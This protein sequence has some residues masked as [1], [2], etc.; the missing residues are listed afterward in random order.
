M[1]R[2]VRLMTAKLLRLLFAVALLVLAGWTFNSSGQTLT[3]LWSF[4]NGVD[5]AG[6][7]AG[8]VQ[9]SDGNLYGTTGSP[10]YPNSTSTVY[11]ITPSGIL[12]NLHTFSGNDGINPNALVQDAGSFF[13]G[14]T[15]G[16]FSGPSISGTVFRISADGSFTNLYTFSGSDGS[17]PLA[18]L[19]QGTDGNFY[20]TTFSG[21]VSN[22]GTVFQISPSG[23]FTNLYSF[24]G[25]DGA[26]PDGVL[27]QGIDGNFYGIA[28][29][30]GTNTNVPVFGTPFPGPGTVFRI[31]PSGSFTNLHSFN[32]NDGTL[33]VGGLAR[34]SDGYFYGTTF[35]GGT[36]GNNGT[37][38]RITPSGSLTSLWSFTGFSDGASPNAGLVQGSDGL[39][40]GTTIGG[41]GASFHGT[42][43]RISSSGSLTTLHT[44]S[45]SGTDE[46]GPTAGLVQGS[47]GTFYGTT[48]SGGTNNNGTVFRLSVSL[49]PPANKISQIQLS[50]TNII[51]GIPS[52]A[53]ETYQLQ[54]SGSMNPT[55]WVN[56]PGAAVTNCIGA[57]MTMTNL[58]GALGPQ[59]F[60]RFDITP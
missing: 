48:V 21:G 42:V 12:T 46:S 16:R 36:N 60:Y 58:G 26:G 13:Y 55:N 20:G 34:G 56:V 41:F 31:S 2:Y 59:G 29:C 18:G 51:V 22:L 7:Y 45:L 28:Y 53:Y 24:S 38:F 14:T 6:P 54:F 1:P 27:V 23:S 19:T 52:V 33:P 47:D 8:L 57:L 49:N 32:G 9:G 30:G 11:R 15:Q 5:G 35:Y 43:F 50:G 17:R 3:T 37:V 10:G 25:I 4:T 44:F 40:Y 39:F